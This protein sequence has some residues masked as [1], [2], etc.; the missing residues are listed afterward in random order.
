[1]RQHRSSAAN[2]AGVNESATGDGVGGASRLDGVD[3]L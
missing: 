1:M 2:A 3:R